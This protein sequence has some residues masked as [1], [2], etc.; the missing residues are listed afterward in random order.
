[1]EEVQHCTVFIKQLFSMLL[2]WH[3]RELQPTIGEGMNFDVEVLCLI[4]ETQT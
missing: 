2:N 1:M 3:A 4:I